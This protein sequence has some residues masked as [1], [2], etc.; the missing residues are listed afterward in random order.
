MYSCSRTTVRRA[1]AQ[2]TAEGLVLPVRRGG[3]KVRAQADRASVGLDT[4]AYRDDLGY[5]FSQAVQ[6]WRAL[7][8]P[9]VQ[10]GPCPP[11]VAPL[12]GLGFGEPVVIRDRVMGDPDTGKVMQLATSYLPADL[13]DGTVLA[14]ADTGPGGIYDRMENDLGWG[15]LDWE[16]AISARPATPEESELL[17]LEPGVPVLCVTR[18]TIA[19]AGSAEGRVVEV[20][21]TRRDASR[22]QVRYAINRQT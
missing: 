18:M 13:A 1:I 11:D 4:T 3:T 12:L 16:G 5:Y 10:S 14:Q 15:S 9:T 17:G 7:R 19:T 20:N 8:T 22:F 2:L 6:P 21:L